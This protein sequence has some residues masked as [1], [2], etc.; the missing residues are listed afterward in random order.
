MSLPA[1]QS[2]AGAPGDASSNS[3]DASL[4]DST[5]LSELRAWREF[6]EQTASDPDWLLVH[7]WRGSDYGER[8]AAAVVEDVRHKLALAP[9][10][11]VLEVGCASGVFLSLVLPP[12]QCGLGFDHCEALVRRSSDFGIDRRRIRLGVSEAAR[13]PVESDS[14]DKVFCYSVFQCFPSR[15]Y[16]LQAVGEFLRVCKAGGTVL[17]GDVFGVMEKQRRRLCSVG[18]P[19]L[20]VD[21]LLWP[22]MPTWHAAQWVRWP[23]DGMRRR[24]YARNFFRRALSRSDCEVEFLSQRISGRRVSGSRYDVRIHKRSAC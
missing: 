2:D 17:I 20:L 18:L 3:V 8:V 7:R 23:T 21:C 22:L 1:D 19:S 24:A 15:A 11:R 5:E 4:P 16:A 13:L 12:D 10:D 6:Y 9:G 14:F